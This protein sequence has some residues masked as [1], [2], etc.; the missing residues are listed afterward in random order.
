MGWA[1]LRGRVAAL[2]QHGEQEADPVVPVMREM[3]E[4]GKKVARGGGAKF[5]AGFVRLPDEAAVF[6]PLW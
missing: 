4:E 5:Y 1:R 2:M 3:T 6:P